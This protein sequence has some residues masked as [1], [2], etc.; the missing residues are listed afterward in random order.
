[1]ISRHF[2]FVNLKRS[3][4]LTGL[5]VWAA[6]GLTTLSQA[7][8]ATLLAHAA[9]MAGDNARTRLVIDFDQKPDFSIHYVAS[10]NRL[11]I[12]LPETKFGF[13]AEALRPLGLFSEIRYGQMGEGRSRIVLSAARPLKVNR[14]EVLENGPQK[15]FRLVI[16]CEMTSQKLFSEVVRQQN[17]TNR[18]EPTASA[19]IKPATGSDD[20][21]V[22]VDA[23]HGGI[24]TGAIGVDSKIEE[25]ILTLDFARELADRLNMVPGIRAF[26]VRDKDVFISLSE[27]VTIARQRQA[28]LFISLH[29]DTLSQ[30]NIRGATVYTLSDK[31]SDSFAADLAAREN[32][33]DVIGGVK[34]Q[35]EPEEVTD[36]LIDLT[37]RETQAFSVRLAESVV[38]SFEGQIKLINNPHRQAGFR[39]LQAPDVPSILLEL[40]FLSNVDDEKILLD[41]E[42]RA[43]IAQKLTDAVRIY[44]N[45]ALAKGG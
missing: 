34:F 4:W 15:G 42:W 11:V 3:L 6:L 24:D 1:M 13:Q 35:N 17:W 31:A 16:D 20:F 39:V 38:A 26:L 12:D 37:R 5:L 36:I 45:P 7:S 28:K 18:S 30:K 21:L 27:R 10:P 14:A 43:K 44:R 41:S 40:G 33:S 22:A 19:D 9:R 25:K 2:S 29:A 8:E 32:L 23:G